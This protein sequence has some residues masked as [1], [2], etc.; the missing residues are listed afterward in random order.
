MASVCSIILK[1][2]RPS[3][4]HKTDNLK[5]AE[6]KKQGKLGQKET[7]VT[8]SVNVRMHSEKIKN[9]SLKYICS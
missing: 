1:Y 9:I 2:T 6:V 3:I 5:L 8:R 4:Q 7:G